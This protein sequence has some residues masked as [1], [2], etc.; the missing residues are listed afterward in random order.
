MLSLFLRRGRKAACSRLRVRRMLGTSSDDSELEYQELRQLKDIKSAE[1]YE[2]E[3]EKR[4]YFYYV[5]LQ[6]RLFLED[7]VPKNIATSLKSDKFLN[8]FFRQL[9]YN[10]TA[11]FTEYPYV[12]PCGKEMNFIKSADLPFVFLDYDEAKKTLSWGHSLTIPFQPDR[13]ELSV[14]TGRLYHPFFSRK[15]VEGDEEVGLLKSHLAIRFSE[16][17]SECEDTGSWAFE[18]ENASYPIKVWP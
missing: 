6:G 17:I 16:C 13:L 4:N 3:G 5:D 2:Q 18:W 9:R 8:F 12:S 10:N 15:R 11:E 7:M 14:E 1:F